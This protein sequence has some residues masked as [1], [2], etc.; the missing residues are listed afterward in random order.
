MH[1]VKSGTSLRA[2]WYA[3]D[4]GSGRSPTRFPMIGGSVCVASGKSVM[5]IVIVRR[6]FLPA[7]VSTEPTTYSSVRRFFASKRDVRRS[8]ALSQLKPDAS[9]FAQTDALFTTVSCF[10][11]MSDAMRCRMSSATCEPSPF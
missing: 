1:L 11:G 5:S 6:Y 8:G 3:L 10:D 9:R 7:T 4:A 2:A